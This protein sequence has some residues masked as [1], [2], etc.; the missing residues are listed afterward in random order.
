MSEYVRECLH[1]DEEIILF[2]ARADAAEPSSVLLR[3]PAST[4]PWPESLKKK[5]HDYSLCSDFSN[6]ITLHSTLHDMI[7][8]SGNVRMSE[9]FVANPRTYTLFTEHVECQ[10]AERSIA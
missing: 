3:S 6:P 4:H 2:R 1:K 9:P 5:E 7:L 10:E 8:L